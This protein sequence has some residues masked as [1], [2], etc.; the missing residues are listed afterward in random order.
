MHFELPL[1]SFILSVLMTLALVISSFSCCRVTPYCIYFPTEKAYTQPSPLFKLHLIWLPVL[2]LKALSSLPPSPPHAPF[3]NFGTTSL[4][5]SALFWTCWFV[6]ILSPLAGISNPWAGVVITEDKQKLT[7][8][9][10]WCFQLQIPHLCP[11]KSLNSSSKSKILFSI[12]M[13]AL[14]AICD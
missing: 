5:S 2:Q 1:P 14:D 3:T 13:F 8:A 7:W 12:I 11:V 9:I 4:P 10:S 6:K